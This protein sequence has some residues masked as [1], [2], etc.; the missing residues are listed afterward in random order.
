MNRAIKLMGLIAIMI[1]AL[2]T[3]SFSQTYKLKTTSISTRQKTNNYEWGDWSEWKDVSMLITLNIDEERITIYSK[4]KQVYDIVDF[5]DEKEDE[6]GNRIMTFYC[7]D[8]DGGTCRLRMVKLLSNEVYSQL[9]IDY[10]TVSWVYSFYY[11]D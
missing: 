5:E 3:F 7:V 2:S 9:Y 8:N 1:L 10:R 11:L 4:E 6:D